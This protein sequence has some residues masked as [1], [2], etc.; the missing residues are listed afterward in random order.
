MHWFK[1]TK[2]SD[3]QDASALQLALLEEAERN[4]YGDSA[5]YRTDSQDTETDYS[6][7]NTKSSVYHNIFENHKKNDATFSSDSLLDY[8]SGKS[9]FPILDLLLYIFPM[10]ITKDRRNSMINI[11]GMFITVC[12]ATF[13]W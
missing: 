11:T 7:F 2:T 3:V 5:L 12:F 13:Y 8:G 6:K 9:L 10:W 1:K 4:I